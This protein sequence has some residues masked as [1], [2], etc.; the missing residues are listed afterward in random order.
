MSYVEKNGK[1]NVKKWNRENVY[2]QEPEILKEEYIEIMDGL[3][4]GLE[5][6]K[7]AWKDWAIG[8][9][10]EK[11]MIKPAKKELINYINKWLNKNI[12]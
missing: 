1:F 10:T 12:K 9:E 8:D 3:D 2:L 7:D 4:E 6:I 5:L 11:D